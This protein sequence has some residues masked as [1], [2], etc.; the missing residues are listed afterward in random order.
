MK[1]EVINES[2]PVWEVT[3]FNLPEVELEWPEENT[4]VSKS[5]LAINRLRIPTS[6]DD[7]IPQHKKFAKQWDKHTQQIHEY[8]CKDKAFEEAPELTSSWPRGFENLKWPQ[9]SNH[10]STIE[11]LKDKP[12]FFMTPH[13]DNREVIGVLIINL[14][15]NNPGSGTTFHDRPYGK[16]TE[17]IWWEGP[18]K[19]HSGVF[20][21]NN[22]N[23]WHSI[24]NFGAEDRFIAYQTLNIINFFRG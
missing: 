3:D 23:T 10:I 18:T 20:I 4:E 2:Y 11:L 6:L 12:D 14:Q 24:K 7:N 5:K 15:D 1:L 17:N 22:W 13:I 16:N 19:K 21:I 9:A 8:L